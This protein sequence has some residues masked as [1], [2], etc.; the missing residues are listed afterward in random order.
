MNVYKLKINH[1]SS[2]LKK[3]EFWIAF[4][5]LTIALFLFRTSIPILK[6]P[7]IPLYFI[8]VVYAV[9]CSWKRFLTISTAFFKIYHI[10]LILSI[11]LIVSFILTYKIY[12]IIFKEAVSILVLLSLF[13]ILTIKIKS[14]KQLVYFSNVLIK[15]FLFFALLIS[16]SVFLGSS[17]IFM[18]EQV[19]YTFKSL[20]K[21]IPLID[22]NFSLIPVFFG[23]FIIFS[24]LLQRNSKFMIIVY[25]LLLT[26][27]SLHIVFSKSRRGVLLLSMIVI[28]LLLIRLISYFKESRYLYLVNSVSKY[29]LITLVFCAF[30]VYIFIFHTSFY[31]K[32]S[33]VRLFV[34]KLTY[35]TKTN[36]ASNLHRNLSSY[37]INISQAQVYNR[38][39]SIK[40]DPRFPDEGGWGTCIHET[41]YPLNGNNS[42]IVPSDSRGYM[43]D[44]TCNVLEWNNNA[45]SETVLFEEQINA[46]DSINASIYCFVSKEY[47]GESVYLNLEG[48]NGLITH[49]DYNL[50]SKDNWQKLEIASRCNI[51]GNIRV[52]IGFWRYKKLDFSGLKGHVIFSYPE[53][54]VWHDDESLD[55]DSIP[56]DKNKSDGRDLSGMYN[57]RPID[58][59][60]H[61]NDKSNS[62]VEIDKGV[63]NYSAGILFLYY[64]YLNQKLDKDPL[65]NWVSGLISEDTT[66]VGPAAE[67]TV[68][69]ITDSFITMRTSRWKFAWRIFTQEYSWRNRIFGGG[70]GFL[71]WY[72]NYFQHD[73]TKCDYPH[74]PF[75]SILLYSGILGLI[76][77]IILVYKVFRIYLSFLKDFPLLPIFFIIVF[78]FSF[79][80]SAT[81][82]DPPIMGFFVILSFLIQRVCH[83]TSY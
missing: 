63:Y 29:Y 56:Y 47:N 53:V 18:F 46:G 16:S 4:V 72:G 27:F 73:K 67:L 17:K 58:K 21:E 26:L 20:S 59:R 25:N 3:D 36:I 6:Y 15:L 64:N 68:D 2:L 75:L 40:Y 14:K 51:D 39:W 5:T 50:K 7:F 44:S 71:N 62:Y 31:V 12:L 49:N 60:T 9:V 57:F 83:S 78:F 66:Y 22:W 28:L 32:D 74:N 34:G 65:R 11:Y 52:I 80:S 55:S 33:V 79:F 61:I 45:Y 77:Y 41:V 13:Y 48:K 35:I 76:L 38:L 37:N 30:L 82:F 54:K 81:P 19:N 1:L 8:S 10:V 43:L 70:F 69:T 42:E 24:L 23:I